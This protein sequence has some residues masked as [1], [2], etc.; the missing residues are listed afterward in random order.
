MTYEYWLSCFVL[1]YVLGYSTWKR[2]FAH[3]SS[4][5]SR[6]SRQRCQVPPMVPDGAYASEH[7][8][9]SP[10]SGRWPKRDDN[11]VNF[12]PVWTTTNDFQTGLVGILFARNAAIIILRWTLSSASSPLHNNIYRYLFPIILCDP[13]IWAA[14]FTWRIFEGKEPRR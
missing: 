8:S 6:H 14:K 7:E 3:A 11:V 4:T 13:R 1:L 9:G 2:G 5:L 10:T 12:P